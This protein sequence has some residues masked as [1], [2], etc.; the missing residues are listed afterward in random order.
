MNQV[1]LFLPQVTRSFRSEG[2]AVDSGATSHVTPCLN[3]WEFYRILNIQEN[4]HCCLSWTVGIF[5]LKLT[6]LLKNHLIAWRRIEILLFFLYKSQRFNFMHIVQRCM[7]SYSVLRCRIQSRLSL[8]SYMRKSKP[9][10][11]IRLHRSLFFSWKKSSKIS[12][13]AFA[14]VYT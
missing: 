4:S 10:P 7:A 5:P 11:T 6:S 2:W 14:L 1:R 3:T 13:K 8:V 9:Y 12:D